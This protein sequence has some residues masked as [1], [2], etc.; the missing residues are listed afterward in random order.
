VSVIPGNFRDPPSCAAINLS[1]PSTNPITRKRGPRFETSALW[2]PTPRDLFFVDG[3]WKWAVL[4]AAAIQPATVLAD[5]PPPEDSEGNLPSLEVTLDLSQNRQSRECERLFLEDGH[6]TKFLQG[7]TSLDAVG[8]GV[9]VKG[10]LPFTCRLRELSLLEPRAYRFEKVS[11]NGSETKLQ[12]LY[13]G[14]QPPPSRR[15][16]VANCGLARIAEFLEWMY[17]QMGNRVAHVSALGLSTQE[18]LASAWTRPRGAL[19]ERK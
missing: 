12:G 10:D 9:R 2:F 13:T 4:R 6:P 3:R 8:A 19:E 1:D 17:F 5:H 18:R 16:P 11:V 15:C 14:L 7:L